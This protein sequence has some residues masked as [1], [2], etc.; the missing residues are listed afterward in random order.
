M[1]KWVW[2]YGKSEILP[3]KSRIRPL[4]S[5]TWIGAYLDLPGSLPRV[6]SLNESFFSLHQGAAGL[7]PEKPQMEL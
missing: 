7:D 4:I 2:L 5:R 3:K 1:I 6:H